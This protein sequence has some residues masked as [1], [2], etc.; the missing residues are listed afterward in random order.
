MFIRVCAL[1]HF[2]YFLADMEGFDFT[3]SEDQ[4]V[5]FGPTQR[6][7][8]AEGDEEDEKLAQERMVRMFT[9]P[10]FCTY[11]SVCLP[12]SLSLPALFLS[13]SLSLSVCLG[14]CRSVCQSLSW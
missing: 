10:S 3:Y 11:L 1:R 4:A 14:G 8:K 13:L 6:D 5:F 7:D 2:G 9:S 12:L